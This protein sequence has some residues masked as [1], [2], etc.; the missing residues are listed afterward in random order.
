M[1]KKKTHDMK[2][3]TLGVFDDGSSHAKV[4]KSMHARG[5]TPEKIAK[6]IGLTIK[7]VKE[8]LGLTH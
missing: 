2:P 8:I 1:S 5:Q 7:Q 6:A 3:D 4:A